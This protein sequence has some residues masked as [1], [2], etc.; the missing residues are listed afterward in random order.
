[1]AELPE[2]KA[3]NDA[4]DSNVEQRQILQKSLRA[5]LNNVRRSVDNLNTTV[6]ELLE[7]Q[8]SGWEATR[9]QEGLALEASRE[10]SRQGGGEGG[11]GDVDI[12]GDVNLDASKGGSGLFGKIGSAIAGSIG[13]LF[14]GLG[15]GGGALLAGAGILAG[16][17][18]FL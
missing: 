18:G 14:K 3:T 9:A 8:R 4:S 2:V 17:A 10:A 7:L 15:I 12:A 16:G 11:I 5:G 13:G 1:M 6:T